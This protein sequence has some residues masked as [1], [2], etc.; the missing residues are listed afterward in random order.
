VN[1]VSEERGREARPHLLAQGEEGREEEGVGGGLKGGLAAL[2]QAE[3][4]GGGLE[5]LQMRDDVDVVSLR[6][7]SKSRNVSYVT[8][9]GQCFTHEK[10]S[11]HTALPHSNRQ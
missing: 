4:T 10:P 1:F 7:E 2:N 3:T 8:D 6:Y 5:S 11:W 9:D